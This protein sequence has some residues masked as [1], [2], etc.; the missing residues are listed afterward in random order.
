MKLFNLTKNTE[1]EFSHNNVQMAFAYAIAEKHGLMTQFGTS[2]E[3]IIEKYVDGNVR[4]GEYGYHLIDLSIPFS[5]INENVDDVLLL[6]A[7]HA[8][9]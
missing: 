8:K 2:P 4:K 1:L 6:G 3:K 7:N 5:S 9:H